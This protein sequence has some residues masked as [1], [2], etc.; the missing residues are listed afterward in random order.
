MRQFPSHAHLASWAGISPGNN[1]SAGKRYSGRI[2]PGNKWLKGC[3]AEA[4]WAASRTKDTYLKSRYQRLAARRGKK[5][6]VVAIG[7]TLLIMA[8]H[9]VKEQK[10]YR[11]LG[12]DYFDRLNEQATLKRLTLRIE[13]LGYNVA[14]SKTASAA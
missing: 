2:T 14:L 3:L 10:T 11:E 5:R 8:Y 9:I 7:H 12:G 6:A 1:E 4:A 13:R